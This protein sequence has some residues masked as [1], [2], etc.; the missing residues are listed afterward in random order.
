VHEVLRSLPAGSHV[1]DLGCG[2]G[3][4]DHQSFPLIVIALDADLP[5]RTPRR[6]VQ[7]DAALLPF[8]AASFD[9]VIS[10]HSMEHIAQLDPALQE[11]SRVLRRPG[12]LFIAVPD[13]TTLTDRLYRWLAS[14]GGHLNPFSSVEELT[15]KIRQHIAEPLAAIRPLYTSLSFLNKHNQPTRPPRRLRLIGG[16]SEP[17]LR[18]VNYWLRWSDRHLNTRLSIYGWALF[19]GEYPEP[20]SPAAWVNV[21]IR[22]GSGSPAGWL[23]DLGTVRKSVWFGHVYSCPDCGTSNVFTPDSA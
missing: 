6:F 5:A 23:R 4:F 20:V 13:S 3:S 18:T 16:G 22:C 9:A 14:G 1:L 2:P 17:L 15:A 7:A 19:F 11:I 21:C 8:A 10:N 12:K